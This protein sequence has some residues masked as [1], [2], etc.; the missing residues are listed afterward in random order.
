VIPPY[1]NRTAEQIINQEYIDDS[2][3]HIH[4]ALS[5][6]DYAEQNRAPVV[7]HYAAFHL[8]LGIELLWLKVFSASRG[9]EFGIDDYKRALKSSTTLYKLTD[10]FAP[11]YRKFAEFDQII[12]SIDPRAHPPTIIWDIARLRKIHGGCGKYLL[13]LQASGKT[14]Y[15]S[16]SWIANRT[17]FLKASA[18]WMWGLMTTRGNLVVYHPER[19]YPETR[20]VWESYLKDKTDVEG[21]RIRLKLIR[22]LL[23][24]REA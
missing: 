24:R 10:R 13:H 6:I 11:N 17:C 21:A 3:W 18:E 12:Q 9:A 14:G 22:P 5:W 16:K 15:W 1:K 7:L 8:R 23:Q 4:A 19:L 2:A 20:L